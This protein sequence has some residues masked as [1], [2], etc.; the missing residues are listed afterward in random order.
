MTAS[1]GK[2][3][4]IIG[5]TGSMG[6]Y[7]VPLLLEQ[8]WSVDV[9]ALENGTVS[10][11]RLTY[12]IADAKQLDTLK[13]LLANRYD[14]VIDFLNYTVDEYR[15]R[16]LL[17]LQNTGHYI[18]LSSYRVYTGNDTLTGE[19]SP[20]HRDAAADPVFRNSADYAIN[21]AAEEDMLTASG[22]GNWTIVR[23]SI[24]FSRFS[25]PLF[26]LGAW[27]IFNR[28]QEGKTVL[29]PDLA[30]QVRGTGTW[31][32]DIARMFAGILFNERGFAQAYTFATH[33]HLAWETW[34][35]YYKSLL[36]LRIDTIEME[37]FLEIYWNK[38]Q[39]A[40]WQITYDRILN[41]AMDNSKILR[42]I[43][44][45]ASD[46]TPVYRA[47]ELELSGIPKSFRFGGGEAV[48]LNMDRYLASGG[49]IIRHL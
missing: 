2:R 15:Q 25:L 27:A 13:Q 44:M 11:P 14:A 35:W 3:I 26:S 47:L 45:S 49:K 31:S 46:L 1:N 30:R 29:I 39:W 5:G 33:E 40:V 17:F 41:R 37:D 23:P 42:D 48:A 32:G 8:G 4:L 20:R 16:Y 24:V 22:A 10:H 34:G 21:K 43:G 18:F 28:A 36:G 19:N 9:A 6:A 38:A 12:R 7:L